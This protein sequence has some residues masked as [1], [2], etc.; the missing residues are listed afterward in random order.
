MSTTYTANAKLQKPAAA[1]RN[2]DV[3]LNANADALDAL[4]PVGGGCVTLHE[5]P[6]STLNV[7]V[8]GCF[9]NK[10]DGTVGTYAGT[11]SQALTAS[12]TNYLFLDGS[13]TLTV[14]TTGFPT[15]VHFRLATV[16]AG[17]TTITS[18]TDS[19]VT[20]QPL[21]AACLLLAGGTLADGANIAVGST[22]G[23]KLGTSVS[24]KL[25]LFNAT[26]VVQPSGAS[27]AAVSQTQTS[28]TDSTGGSVSTTLAAIT[29]GASY[30]QADLVALKNAVAS[31]AA[32]LA[33]V[34]TDVAN[35]QTLGNAVRSALVAIG[36]IKGSA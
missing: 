12:N 13:G 6:S 25:G 29:A 5:T 23:T 19:R 11:A 15:T 3:P 14:N 7:A 16:V 34:K 28:L 35:T 26:P 9:Y 8:A 21:A 18:I 24:Q 36:A 1:D 17:G 20:L 2:W 33:L 31:L 22:T 27:Q 30:A 10:T 32:E 4:A